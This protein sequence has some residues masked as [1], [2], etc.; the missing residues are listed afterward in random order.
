[1]LKKKRKLKDSGLKRLRK[2]RTAQRVESSADTV[3]NDQEDASK[4]GEIAKLDADK[5]VTLEEVTAKVT[6]D[7]D[8]Q[9]MLEESQAHAYH[10]ELE[11]AQKVLSMQEIDEAEPTEVEEASAPRRR[12]GVIIQDPEEATTTSLSVQSKVKLKHK[13]KG[14]LVEEPKP[15]KRQ[16]QIEQDEAYARELEVELNANI[17]WNDVI[18]QVKRKEKQDN[19]VMRYQALKRKPVAEAQ[20]RKNMMSEIYPQVEKVVVEGMMMVEQW[21]IEVVIEVE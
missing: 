1:R 9:G 10:L 17:N 6:K 18:E 16:A 21:E 13:G 5:Y 8:V 7:A 14:I 4:Q 19:T 3:M 11:H 15:L 20:A 2:V 12:K